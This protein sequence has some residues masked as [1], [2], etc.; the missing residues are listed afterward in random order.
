VIVS[1]RLIKCVPKE[2]LEEGANE[3]AS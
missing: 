3:D 2:L 1:I